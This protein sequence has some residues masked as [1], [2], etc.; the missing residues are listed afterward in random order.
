MNYKPKRAENLWRSVKIFRPGTGQILN[1]LTV[2]IQEDASIARVANQHLAGFEGTV[3]LV[4]FDRPT[5][6][7]LDIS[8]NTLKNI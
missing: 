7:C 3:H 6:L 2:M 4:R 5:L 8:V 1:S